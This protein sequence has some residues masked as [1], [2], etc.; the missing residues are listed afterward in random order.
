MSPAPKILQNNVPHPKVHKQAPLNCSCTLHMSLLSSS[1][2]LR[3]SELSEPEQKDR[4]R[5]HSELSELE[6][7]D[8]KRRRSEQMCR[9]DVTYMVE[10]GLFSLFQ[11]MQRG[12]P[13]PRTEPNADV[14]HLI[15]PAVFVGYSGQSASEQRSCLS[16]VVSAF[17]N[18][19][20]IKFEKPVSA[21]EPLREHRC[22]V[23]IDAPGDY[24]VSADAL[25]SQLTTLVMRSPRSKPVVSF[26]PKLQDLTAHGVK[27]SVFERCV[28]FAHLPTTWVSGSGWSTHVSVELF[29]KLICPEQKM[30]KFKACVEIGEG[31]NK[32]FTLPPSI[33]E[34][35]IAM[36]VSGERWGATASMHVLVPEATKLQN[37]EVVSSPL[38]GG[39]RIS[40]EGDH[41]I[42][43]VL[44]RDC[45]LETN[46]IS[47]RELV[48]EKQ[49]GTCGGVGECPLEIAPCTAKLVVS[50]EKG[51]MPIMDHRIDHLSMLNIPNGH[52]LTLDMFPKHQFGKVVIGEQVPFR[53]AEHIAIQGANN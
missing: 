35:G 16:W 23:S 40:V 24:E 15:I 45:I 47:A 11:K 48:L 1:P 8:R 21:L 46:T 32:E 26:P 22:L 2:K 13:V 3:H 10:N 43:R 14:R 18:A 31:D 20:T 5:R 33:S 39:I 28:G 50:L 37:L 42:D 7:K 51:P 9:V 30:E 49:V 12:D 29:E 34:F 52:S 19:T 25:P 41:E 38:Y 17:P 53:I 4:K 36:Y 44:L 27:A 6:Q